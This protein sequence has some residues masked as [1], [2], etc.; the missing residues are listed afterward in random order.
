VNCPVSLSSRVARVRHRHR[1]QCQFLRC[2]VKTEQALAGLRLGGQ[3]GSRRVPCAVV[4]PLSTP[5]ANGAVEP[6]HHGN[7]PRVSG[8]SP[9]FGIASYGQSRAASYC[10]SPARKTRRAACT[11]ISSARGKAGDRQASPRFMGV[12]AA[13]RHRGRQRTEALAMANVD[14]YSGPGSIGNTISGR[15]PGAGAR[16]LDCS[17]ANDESRRST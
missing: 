7:T 3:A 10:H 12:V 8:S 6:K 9:S 4:S 2:P 5:A 11:T 15:R 16:A 14:C 13:G 17:S 1:C